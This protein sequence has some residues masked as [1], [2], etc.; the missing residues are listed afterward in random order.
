V[1][2]ELNSDELVVKLSG[3]SDFKGAVRAKDLKI[4]LSGASDVVY[5]RQYN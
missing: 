1:N 3:A 4:D 5:K 2:G